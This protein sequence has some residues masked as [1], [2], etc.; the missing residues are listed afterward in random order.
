M[1]QLLLEY[2]VFR[3]VFLAAEVHHRMYET[4]NIP[5]IG[6]VGQL[7]NRHGIKYM[8]SKKLNITAGFVLRMNFNPEPG[9]CVRTDGVGAKDMA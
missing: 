6:R 5:Y 8:F 3:E 7:Y 1:V 9:K 4:P 2:T